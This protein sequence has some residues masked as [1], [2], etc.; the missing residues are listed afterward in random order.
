VEGGIKVANYKLFDWY[1]FLSKKVLKSEV[2][3][4][5]NVSLSFWADGPSTQGRSFCIYSL[6]GNGWDCPITVDIRM[7]VT[8]KTL[9]G[10]KKEAN[11]VV[12][13]RQWQIPLKPGEIVLASAPGYACC[14]CK[15]CTVTFKRAKVSKEGKGK[16][17][18]KRRGK[19]MGV[20][21]NVNPLSLLLLPLGFVVISWR[22]GA[23]IE[24]PVKKD[25]SK[26]EDRD[27]DLQEQN[28]LLKSI[29][30]LAEPDR[31][32]IR[33]LG[34]AFRKEETSHFE[35]EIEGLCRDAYSKWCRKHGQ[36]PDLEVVS[37]KAL[38]TELLRE[39]EQ[40]DMVTAIPVN[41]N[42]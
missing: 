14:D 36:D 24:L 40:E 7:K 11:K 30:S 33:P 41:A 3:N 9:L 26:T 27:E 25:K 13:P 20:S 28:L 32:D 35:A 31:L 29:W 18:L 39:S 34:A 19:T 23:S 42:W 4:A 15:P 17:V 38:T 16:C 22:N 6:V 37:S 2:Y 12:A 10:T 21:A 1:A 8:P 5:K